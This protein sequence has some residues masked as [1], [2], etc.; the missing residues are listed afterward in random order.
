MG[1]KSGNKAERD[2]RRFAVAVGL[3]GFISYLERDLAKDP[4]LADPR[5]KLKTLEY[6]EI[7]G[8]IRRCLPR[9]SHMKGPAKTLLM[10][11]NAI[12]CWRHATGGSSSARIKAIAKVHV[13]RPGDGG[14]RGAT[15]IIPPKYFIEKQIPRS[16]LTGIWDATPPNRNPI[17][18]FATKSMNQAEPFGTHTSTTRPNEEITNPL[19]A[20]Y[21]PWQP[22]WCVKY[23]IPQNARNNAL[24]LTS[25]L[26]G[27]SIFVRGPA[28]NP[29]V[30][31]CGMLPEF[32]KNAN[33]S[34]LKLPSTVHG[35]DAHNLLLKNA[36]DN[37]RS[38]D[39][40][41]LIVE[42][43]GAVDAGIGSGDY[44]KGN[45]SCHACSNDKST[46]QQERIHKLLKRTL[47]DRRIL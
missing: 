5:I 8:Y 27:C 14:L 41:K 16:P 11:K 37:K 20:Y 6:H 33:L 9:A 4:G 3:L 23:N 13:I 43:E 19:T 15:P 38:H 2:Y 44:S 29:T 46:L 32:W 25:A 26:S 12:N 45:V 1:T 34:K 22:G 35:A 17:Q 21:L 47:R 10:K 31:H 24:F 42:R 40:F 36:I 28:T 18:I 7:A 39:F 30:Y